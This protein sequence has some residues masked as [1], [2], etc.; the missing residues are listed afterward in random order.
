MNMSIASNLLELVNRIGLSDQE[1]LTIL[2]NE[3]RT[4]QDNIADSPNTIKVKVVGLLVPPNQNSEF[5]LFEDMSFIEHTGTEYLTYL[6]GK[7][8]TKE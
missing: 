7:I 3:T 4:N 6:N 8:I 2:R 5:Y 1:L